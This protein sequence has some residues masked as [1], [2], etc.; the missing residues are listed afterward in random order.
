MTLLSKLRP[1]TTL[2][3]GE[4]YLF[5]PVNQS[6]PSTEC[7]W[8]IFNKE[9]QGQIFLESSS[10][11]LKHFRLWHLLPERYRLC[12]IATRDELRDYVAA[13]SHTDY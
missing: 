13:I 10:R 1:K 8:G 3:P 9:E 5:C 12:R 4:L 7:I 6:C 2:H 11:D